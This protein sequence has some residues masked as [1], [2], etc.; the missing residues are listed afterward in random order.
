MRNA[1]AALT[2]A[3][4]ASAGLPIP[5]LPLPSSAPF[6][7]SPL[8][9]LNPLLPNPLPGKSLCTQTHHWCEAGLYVVKELSRQPDTHKRTHTHSH[10]PSHVRVHTQIEHRLPLAQPDST[11]CRHQWTPPQ[12]PSRHLR[13][14][15][16]STVQPT[17]R[18]I[19][20]LPQPPYGSC[21]QPSSA[22]RLRQPLAPTLLDRHQQPPTPL[23]PTASCQSARLLHPTTPCQF[24]PI[25]QP[26]RPKPTAASCRPLPHHELRTPPICCQHSFLGPQRYGS[27]T[28]RGVS[29]PGQPPQPSAP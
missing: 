11:P 3:F 24:R 26:P 21:V 1:D 22:H 9:N 5:S 6:P 13:R 10:T 7:P 12:Q 19:R 17:C 15:A 4:S 16:C 14:S 28:F 23:Q 18:R 29:S 8:P 25:L 2:A 20:G 27:Y